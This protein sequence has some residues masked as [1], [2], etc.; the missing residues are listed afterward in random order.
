[1]PDEEAARDDHDQVG[2]PDEADQAGE[3]QAG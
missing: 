2:Q 1:V 3:H